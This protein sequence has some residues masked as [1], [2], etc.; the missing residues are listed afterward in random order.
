MLKL[1]GIPNCDTVKK[2]RAYLAAHAQAPDFVDFKKAAP[3]AEDIERWA[4]A[5]GGL[6]VNQKGTSYKK[7]KDEFERLSRPRQIEFLRQN[8][9]LIKRPILERDGQV[10]CFGFDEPS[11]QREIGHVRR[12]S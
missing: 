4:K 10:L 11:Y 2:A 1:Y 5:Y 6:P 3:S 9:S 8:T 12:Q 7:L